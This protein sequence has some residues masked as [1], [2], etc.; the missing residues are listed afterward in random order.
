[1]TH[2]KMASCSRGARALS[3]PMYLMSAL[4]AGD[5]W[6]FLVQGSRATSYHVHICPESMAC[7]CPDF[8]LRRETCKHIFFM[9]GRVLA[10]VALMNDLENGDGPEALVAACFSERIERRL[11]ARLDAAK[12]TCGDTSDNSGTGS[13]PD[14]TCRS[15]ADC[16]VCFEP[17]ASMGWCCK[18]CRKECMHLDCAKRWLKQ[19]PSCP[20]CRHVNP[21]REVPIGQPPDSLASFTTLYS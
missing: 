1:M 19:T 11:R 18:R 4:K 8:Q 20:L 21:A 7:T 12:T 14:E 10:D 13:G 9:V 16:V 5:D 15:E 17:L 3:Q 6:D 2:T